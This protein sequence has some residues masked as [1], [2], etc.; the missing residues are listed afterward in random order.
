MEIKGDAER[1]L[2]VSGMLSGAAA[3]EVERALEHLGK[4]DR[5]VIDFSGVRDFSDFGLAILARA[6]GRW[7]TAGAPIRL[8]GLRQHQ[9]RMFRYLGIDAG[10]RP[11]VRAGGLG[12][13]VRPAL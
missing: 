11:A 12:K 6:L 13:K 10:G 9:L 3:A 7:P 1:T 2:S 4:P 8:R 5:V